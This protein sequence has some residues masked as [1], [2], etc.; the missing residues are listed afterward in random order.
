MLSLRQK[1]FDVEN[2]FMLMF[3][4]P[5]ANYFLSGA[6]EN[7]KIIIVVLGGRTPAINWLKQLP[8]WQVFCA[9]KG[10]D[11]ALTAGRK[12]TLLVGDEDSGNSSTYAKVLADGGVVQKHPVDKDFTDLQLLLKEIEKV[13]CHLLVTG[14][15]GG[16]L[17]HLQSN[18]RSLLTYKKNTGKQVLIADGKETLALLFDG[19]VCVADVKKESL[20]KVGVLALA[21]NSVASMDHVQWPME[22]MLLNLDTPNTLSNRPLDKEMWAQ[23]DKGKIGFYLCFDEANL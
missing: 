3:D 11:Y 22:K 15:L 20:P 13:P 23:C 18:L 21:E 4:L 10:A 16:R 7:E 9:D 2:K 14:A 6:K 12:I 5:E 17:D 8:Q 19:E 1:K